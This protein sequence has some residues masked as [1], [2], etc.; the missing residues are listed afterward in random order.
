MWASGDY[1]AVASAIT[2]GLGRILVEAADIAAGDRVLDVAAGT[3]AAAVH[4]ARAGAQVVASDLTPELFDAGRSN[5]ARHGVDIAWE[6]ADA[7]SLPYGADTFDAV[8]SCVGVMF[9]PHHQAAADELVRVCRPGG[10]IGLLNWTPEGFFGQLLATMKPY[11][12]T[13]PPSAKPP[14][15][16]GNEAHVRGLLG[17]RV[18]DAHAHRANLRMEEFADGVAF[19]DFFKEHYGVTILAYRNVAHDRARTA[20]LDHDIADLARRHDLGGGVM[21]AEYLL[22]TA[23]V[24]A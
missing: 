10:A 23:R 2:E 9:A 18:T 12:P 6:E 20:A 14:S 8:L 5:A 7:E 1:D 3:G 11:L 24:A 17:D 15:L 19:R 21:E 16:W 22:L 4:A 13:P